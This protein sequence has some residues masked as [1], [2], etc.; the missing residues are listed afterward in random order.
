MI[1]AQRKLFLE[2]SK[3]QLQPNDNVV[4]QVTVLLKKCQDIQVRCGS[5]GNS[6]NANLTFKDI[7][8]LVEQNVQLRSLAM[9]LDSQEVEFKEKLEIELKKHTEETASEVAAVLQTEEQ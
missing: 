8:G 5:S 3:F 6:I 2:T 9:S 7:N 4:F 1:L